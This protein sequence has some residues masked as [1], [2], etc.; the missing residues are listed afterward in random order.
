M[1][2]RLYDFWVASLQDG[3]IGNLIDICERAGCAR[4]MYH[5]DEDSLKE[6]LKLTDRLIA[7]IMGNRLGKDEIKRRYEDMERKGI[8]FIDYKEDCYPYRLKNIPSRPYALFVLGKLPEENR[9]SV[10]IVGA[11]ECSEYGRLM[12]EYFGDRLAREGVDIISGMAWGIDGIAQMAAVQ[13]GGNSYGILGCGVDIIYPNR[14]KRLYEMLSEN[15]NGLISE[16]AP[17]TRAEAKH[18]PPRNR[19][20]SG[21]CDILIVVEAKARSG[22]LITVDMAADQGR[23]VMVVPGRVTDALSVGC[24]N[25]MN[26]GALPAVGVDSVLNQLEQINSI[27]NSPIYKGRSERED[28]RRER[29]N[30]RESIS[31]SKI[32]NRLRDKQTVP[33]KKMKRQPLSGDKVRIMDCLGLD[34]IGIDEIANR[35]GIAVASL[36]VIMTELEMDEYI[37]EVGQM[38]FIACFN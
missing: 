5:M 18:F 8:K 6:K 7:H 3:Y 34:P 4:D 20:I 13:A 19:I 32:V 29:T 35:T 9:K 15:G 38:N 37:R 31:D 16:Y 24:L 14:N 28:E 1:E 33:V 27:S 26:E 2:D 21:L 36:M 17:N 12:A 25:L 10:A 23:T 11:R 30:K 22:T